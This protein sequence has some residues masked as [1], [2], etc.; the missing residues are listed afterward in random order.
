MFNKLLSLKLENRIFELFKTQTPGSVKVN[1]LRLM[2]Q[3]YLIFWFIL[4]P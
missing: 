2:Q 4:I 3:D 1:Y